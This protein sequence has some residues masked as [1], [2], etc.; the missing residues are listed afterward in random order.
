MKLERFTYCYEDYPSLKELTVEDGVTVIR[1]LAIW[2]LPN[3]RRINL[4]ASLHAIEAWAVAYCYSLEE[5]HFCGTEKQWK[6]VYKAE[7]WHHNSRKPI[8]TFEN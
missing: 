4:P 7:D 1:R 5:V 8:I 2:G 6:E 3:L